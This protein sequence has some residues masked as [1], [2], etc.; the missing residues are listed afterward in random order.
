MHVKGGLPAMPKQS[1]DPIKKKLQSEQGASI[2]FALLLFLVCAV[3][4]SIVIVAGTAASGRL[5][6]MA[7]MDQRYYSVTSAARLLC[8]EWDGKS[9]TVKVRTETGAPGSTDPE[10]MGG[11]GTERVFVYNTAN[12]EVPED[13]FAL[14]VSKKYE[15]E[16]FSSPFDNLLDN[17]AYWLA[18]GRRKSDS[19]RKPPES[20][21]IEI[22]DSPSMA[23]LKVLADVTLEDDPENLTRG[24]VVLKIHNSDT[25]NGT[26]TLELTFPADIKTE[27]ETRDA[28]GSTGQITVE[29]TEVTWHF[30]SI[31]TVNAMS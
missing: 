31:R 28:T 6:E 16:S 5:A 13:P 20:M 19:S 21:T 10:A 8:E 26:Y 25:T 4:S 12:A 3:I 29:T 24:T 1:M 2:S 17:A 9:V 18:Y 7:K 27:S 22:K 15:I 14:T 23:A 11:T 30:G